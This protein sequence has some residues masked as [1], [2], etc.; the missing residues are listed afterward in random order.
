MMLDILYITCNDITFVTVSMSQWWSTFNVG[1]HKKAEFCQKFCADL[2]I[3]DI[4]ISIA[5][6][7]WLMWRTHG[8]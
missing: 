4:V 8:Q 7:W 3:C 5:R 6:Y 2:S 1:V